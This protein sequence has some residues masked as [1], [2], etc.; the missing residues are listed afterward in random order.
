MQNIVN[1]SYTNKVINIKSELLFREAE[2]DFYYF[3]RLNSAVKKLKTALELTPFHL[4]S[5]I[6]YADI[7]F[8]KGNIKKA[9]ELY[10]NAEKISPFDTKILASLA[11]CYN[12]LKNSSLA[13]LYSNKA[14]DS[15]S[16][17][18]Y[19]LFLQLIDIK[20]N[21]LILLK[22]YK[23]ASIVFNNAQKITDSLS[24]KSLYSDTIIE[25]LKLQ[26]KI[27]FSGLKIV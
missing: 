23:E 6:M 13:I 15:L 9:L 27:N 10:K 26:Q 7:C 5:L 20:V 8:I 24:L 21:N 14:L 2:D 11:N 1:K 18:N 12:F 3:Y 19:S 22:R 16:E 4:K 25:K 17:T